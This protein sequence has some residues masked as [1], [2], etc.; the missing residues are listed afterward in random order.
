MSLCSIPNECNRRTKLFAQKIVS[1]LV[2]ENCKQRDSVLTICSET[3]LRNTYRN[4]NNKKRYF[5]FHC[6]EE[7][8]KYEFSPCFNL[9][10]NVNSLYC[11]LTIPKLIKK[12]KIHW[13][14]QELMLY[15]HYEWLNVDKHLT[16]QRFFR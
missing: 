3:E 10:S 5:T 8:A 1:T 13:P 14:R 6:I 2:K 7:S 15:G 9:L 16:F 11:H 12:R 4:N